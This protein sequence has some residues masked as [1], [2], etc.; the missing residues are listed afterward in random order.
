MGRARW[1]LLCSGLCHVLAGHHANIETPGPLGQQVCALSMRCI[2]S[3]INSWISPD[4]Q[5]SYRP[6]TALTVHA[7]QM[8]GNGVIAGGYWRINVAISS[9]VL[10]G[11]PTFMNC[12]WYLFPQGEKEVPSNSYP[13]SLNR[14]KWESPGVMYPSQPTQMFNLVPNPLWRSYFGRW[15][16][17]IITVRF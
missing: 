7:S 1:R 3:S 16:H 2:R 9:L 13:I 17:S 10:K 11:F 14:Q 12:G 8:K 4:V 15:V 5:V 6:R